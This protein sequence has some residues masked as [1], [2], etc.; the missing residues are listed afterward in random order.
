MSLHIVYMQN[1]NLG[2]FLFTGPKYSLINGLTVVWVI[3]I[4]GD[5]NGTLNISTFITLRNI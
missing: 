5:T 1:V 2:K 4:F 3:F